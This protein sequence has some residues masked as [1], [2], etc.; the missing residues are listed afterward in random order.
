MKIVIIGAGKIGM[1][2]ASTLSVEGHDVTLI[3]N[4]PKIIENAINQHDLTGIVGNGVNFTI[5]R[6]AGV[7]HADVVIAT[8]YSD[9][10]NMLCCLVAKKIGVRH[11]VARIRDPEYSRQFIFM[12]DEMGLDMV[13]NPEMEAAREI[14]RILRYPYAIGVDTFAKGKVDLAEMKIPAGSVL[15]GISVTDI[16]KKLNVRILVCAVQHGDQVYIPR[17]ESVLQAQ[18]HIYFTAPHKELAAFFRK[19]DAYRRKLKN[20][21]IVGGGRIA[22][23]LARQLLELGIGVKLVELDEKRCEVLASL[24]PKAKIIHGDGTD[25]ELLAEEDFAGADASVAVTGIDEENIIL[26]MF[27]IQH[28][29]HKIVTKVSKTTLTD[30]LETIGLDSVITPK[31]ITSDLILGYIRA[32]QAGSGGGV[33]TLY[34]L[35]DGRVEALEFHVRKESKVTHTPLMRLN[36]RVDVLICCIIRAGQIIYP[37]GNDTIEPGDI[38]IVTTTSKKLTALD[39]IL[40]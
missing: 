28:S 26:S 5:Q 20:V 15:D 17:G 27:A 34:K 7:A 10:I 4:D 8:T 19:I 36:L 21:F 16:P 31:N 3:D 1:T 12:L 25:Q 33:Q 14:S 24:L 35:V 6:E 11:T 30:M 32:L 29:I 18:D 13:V 22:Y 38:V 23:Y 9:E 2:L 40:K 37:G 39:D